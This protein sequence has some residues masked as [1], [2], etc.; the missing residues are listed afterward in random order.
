MKTSQARRIDWD[1]V[2][3]AIRKAIDDFEKNEAEH[4]EWAARKDLTRYEYLAA[5]VT[6]SAQ[7]NIDFAFQENHDWKAVHAILSA[8][9]RDYETVSKQDWLDDARRGK[10]PIRDYLCAKL[11]RYVAEVIDFDGYL[12]ANG[13]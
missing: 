9:Y 7:S 2:E 11:T 1:A 3:Y 13:A 4:M 8:V 6:R 5:L 10:Q 12:S